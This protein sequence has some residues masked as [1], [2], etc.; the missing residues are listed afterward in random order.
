MSVSPANISGSAP[1]TSATARRLLSPTNCTENRLS[2][3][4]AFPIT[5]T[6]GFI[7]ALLSPSAP[8][9]AEC[10]LQPPKRFLQDRT[11]RSEIE[12]EPG[13]AARSELRAGAGKD[14]RACL[15]PVGD[16]FGRQAGCGEIDPGE[17]G[18]GEAHRAG[19]GRRG[20]DPR[21][22]KIAVRGEVRQQRVEPGV[23]RPPSRLGRNHAEAV[24]GGKAARADLRIEAAFQRGVGGDARA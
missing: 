24:V 15:D 23:A 11:R 1:A 16:L 13:F 12:A 7:M 20:L 19:A 18:S 2:R 9:I 10:I 6:T 17:V 3:R 14:A 21:V 4:W 8:Q 22:E 5:P